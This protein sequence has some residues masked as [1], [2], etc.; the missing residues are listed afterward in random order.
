MK[1]PVRFEAGEAVF[2]VSGVSE[3]KCT[4]WSEDYTHL[5]GQE[6]CLLLNVYVPGQVRLARVRSVLSDSSVPGNAIDEGEN[7]PV[8][9]WIHGGAFE[10][11]SGTYG[12]YGPQ[13]FMDLGVVVV[14][15]NYRLGPFG[16]LSSAK[17]ELPGNLGLWDQSL[18][19]HWVRDNIQHFGGNRDQ[20]TLFGESAGGER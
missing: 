8:M 1:L 14:T 13:Y 11:G 16:F 12:D 5:L 19:L 2:D 4:Q 6:D 18:A 10:S 20:L 17:E 7:L 15:V 9:V 3:V